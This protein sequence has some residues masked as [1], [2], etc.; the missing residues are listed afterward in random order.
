[1]SDFNNIR[2]QPQRPLLREIS[3]D[4]LN[5]ILQEIKRN[6]PRG[7]RGITVRQDGNGTYIGLAA[8]FRRGS[9]A[10]PVAPQ[11]WDLIVRRDPEFEE[12][13]EES[14]EDPEEENKPY[15]VRVRPGTLNGFLPSNWDDEFKADEDAIYY[16]KAIVSTDG[17]AQTEVTIAIDA[18][19]PVAQE[20]QEFGVAT[21][22]EIVFGLF[23]EGIAYRTI[24]SGNINASPKL[25]LTTER[26]EPPLA[27]ELPFSQ[28]FLFR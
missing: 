14:E 11:P 18:N 21:S 15:L 6:K 27:G 28:Y 26:Q 5:T 22:V 1:M 8:S 10:A 12:P 20:P 16:A 7:E 2:F 9:G 25:W 13:A 17:R 24:G 3:A 19:P 23:A 4:R